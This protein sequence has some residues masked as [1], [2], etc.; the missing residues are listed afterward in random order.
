MA[1]LVQHLFEIAAIHALVFGSHPRQSRIIAAP[2]ATGFAEHTNLMQPTR[3]ILVPHRPNGCGAMGQKCL[4]V[5][6]E[7][8]DKLQCRRS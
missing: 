4:V 8:L 1:M 3:L 7:A 2:R 5:C 6:N